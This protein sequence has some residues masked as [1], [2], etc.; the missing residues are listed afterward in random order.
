MKYT[1]EIL[2]GMTDKEINQAVAEA[3]G[4]TEIGFY[5]HGPASWHGG[6]PPGKKD[7]RNFL[8]W[9][10]DAN[11]ALE[12]LR[13]MNVPNN[14]TTDSYVLWWVWYQEKWQVIDAKSKSLIC[15]SHTAA[16]AIC[17]AYLLW[18]QK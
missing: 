15:K 3:Q 18:A 14:N 9:S 8:E 2:K 1:R 11:A 5:R 10:T 4:W 16:R 6:I 12:L 7:D 13:E 17:E